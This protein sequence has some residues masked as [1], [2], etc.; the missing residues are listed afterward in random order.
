MVLV[1]VPEGMFLMGGDEPVWL[2]DP[3]EVHLEAFWIDRTEVTNAMYADFLNA[4][5]N[6]V[7]GDITWLDANTTGVRIHPQGDL[8]V[9]DAGYEDHPA[10]GV[11]WYGARAYCDWAGRRLPTE[12]EWEKTARGTD[13][14]RY[15][16]GN[17]LPS[18]TLLNSC[19][20][21]C[22]GLDRDPSL[23]DGYARTSPVGSFPAGASPYGALDMAGNVWE[24]VSSRDMDYP[25]DAGDGRE[26][27]YSEGERVMRGGSW[28]VYPRVVY[29]AMRGRLYPFKTDSAIGFRCSRSP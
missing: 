1:Y 17:Q 26:D 29:A 18:G 21:E 10:V 13:G 8:W 14:R 5:G 27:P 28:K 4:R 25:Y 19:D 22:P 20:F 16:W 15:P 6:R 23:N 2:D 7:G 12:A 11:T 9:A 3:H 24:W